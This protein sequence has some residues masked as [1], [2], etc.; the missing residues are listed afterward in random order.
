MVTKLENGER[1]DVLVIGGGCTGSGVALDAALRGLKVVCIEREDFSS[2]T[3]SRSTK[4][5]WGG[6]RYLVSALVS[7]FNPD[8][9]LVK[10][11]IETIRKFRDEFKMVLNCHRERRFLL[12]VQSHLTNWLPIAVPITRWILWPPPFNYPLAAVGP[13]GLFP[14]FFKFYDA[15]SGYTCPPSHIM[16][17]KRAWRKFPQLNV[18]SLKYCAVFYEGQ[19]NDARTNLSISLTAAK[20]GATMLNY[21]ELTKILYSDL[22]KAAGG[23]ILDKLTGKSYNVE[24]DSIVFC[25]GPFTDELRKI[26]NPNSKEVVNGA[27]GTH[28]VI[29]GHYAPR[30]FGLVDMATSDGRFLFYLPWENH[31]W[32]L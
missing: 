5:L 28:I 30:S 23:V 8:L 26:E 4:L 29:P 24:A 9:R 19:H 7:L 32:W 13:I 15:L 25:G 18:D 1:F 3:S 22:G 21:F 12:T 6:S 14:L 31:V 17:K 2:G 20:H 11:P 27:S 10:R 16:S